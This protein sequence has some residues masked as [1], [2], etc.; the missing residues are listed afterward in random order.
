MEDD[1]KNLEAS[2]LRESAAYG[3]TGLDEINARRSI[4]T[5]ALI[6]STANTL[7]PVPEAIRD[8]FQEML[9]LSVRLQNEHYG[10]QQ[11]RTG[12]AGAVLHGRVSALIEVLNWMGSG[13]P[14]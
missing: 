6:T 13:E 7:L 8:H 10:E 12:A 4:V 14:K 9:V 5:S 1:L 3:R 2:I 11:W